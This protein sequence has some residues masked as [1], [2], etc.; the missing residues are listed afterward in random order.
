MLNFDE[1]EGGERPSR[2]C[3]TDEE[4]V[5]RWSRIVPKPEQ[6]IDRF[7]AVKSADP[8]PSSSCRRRSHGRQPTMPDASRGVQQSWSK[9]PSRDLVL[10]IR[11]WHWLCGSHGTA[12]KIRRVEAWHALHERPPTLVCNGAIYAFCWST[13]SQV[14]RSSCRRYY[15]S[16]VTKRVIN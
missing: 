3:G 16:G 2:R 13:T 7:A 1:T 9:L 8:W 14:P 10:L 4:V 11:H 5:V 6:R 15:K 12:R